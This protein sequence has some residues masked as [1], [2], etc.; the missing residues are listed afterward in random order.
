MPW[1]GDISRMGQ[2]ADRIAD[3]ASVPSRASKRVSQG[4]EGLLQE[5]FDAGQD[6]YGT[7]WQPL[8]DETLA[9]RSQTTEPPL[10]D[11]G[12]MR[13]SLGVKPMKGAGVS[14]TIDHPAAPHQTGW[15][16]KQG[17]GPA[18]PILPMRGDLPET[19]IE[20]IE[21]AISDEIKKR[22]PR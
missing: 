8:Q 21:G 14:I 16:G 6:P 17:R 22:G 13:R 18:R 19:W 5:E 4:I 15:V 12:A 7:A 9:K 3:L 2:L 1:D 11:F 20:A 10:T